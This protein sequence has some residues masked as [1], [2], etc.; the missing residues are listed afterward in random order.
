MLLSQDVA[1]PL[2]GDVEGP[3]VAHCEAISHNKKHD[4][5]LSSPLQD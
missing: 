1:V 4:M 2:S 3:T 5:Y